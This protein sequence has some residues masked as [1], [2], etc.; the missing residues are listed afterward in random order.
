MAKRDAEN[1][2]R[3]WRDPQRAGL[4]LLRADFRQ[5]T[6][7][8]HFHEDLVIAGSL[9]GGGHF[10][11]RGARHATG[12]GYLV[13][14]NP[15]EPHEG[16]VLESQGWRYRSIYLTGGEMWTQLRK[17]SDRNISMPYFSNSNLRDQDLA[18]GFLTLHRILGEHGNLIEQETALLDFLATLIGRHG[19]DGLRLESVGPAERRLQNVRDSLHAHFAENIS[20]VNL[21]NLACLSE[22][23]FIRL[24]RK[25]F[26]VS[27]HSYLTQ[28][29]LDAARRMLRNGNPLAET[30]VTVGFCDQSH[31]DRHFKRTYGITPGQFAACFARPRARPTP[32]QTVNNHR[33]YARSLA[34]AR[35]RE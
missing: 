6:F 3:F 27:P 30:A 7:P 9:D 33:H 15:G 1:V 23:H 34:V 17:L 16:K 20:I 11:T 29:R 10:T 24:F 31:L 32:V 18:C 8:R 19:D 12:P 25:R 14:F 28:I 13:V 22:Y 21:A 26:G 5:H 35:A 2:T 4:S